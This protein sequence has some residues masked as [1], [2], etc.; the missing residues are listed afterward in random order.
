MYMK[1]KIVGNLPIRF[2]AESLKK[3]GFRYNYLE[4]IGISLESPDL[5]R[6][7]LLGQSADAFSRREICKILAW[8]ALSAS[9][10]DMILDESVQRGKEAG[11]FWEADELTLSIDE[12]LATPNEKRQ[13]LIKSHHKRV[14]DLL[15]SRSAEDK[16]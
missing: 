4:G 13:D 15:S 1:S 2:V 7:M 11:E 12:L 10:I 16:L 14:N 5:S 6:K 8:F 3:R 9:T